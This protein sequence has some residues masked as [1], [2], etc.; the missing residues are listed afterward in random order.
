[1]GTMIAGPLAATMMADFGADV[2]KIEHPKNGDPIR[3]WTPIRNGV[4][5]WWKMT[6][7]N[8][9]LITLDLARQEGRELALELVRNADLVIENFRPGT[10]ERWGLGYDAMSNANPRVILVRVSG[11]GQTGPY[12]NRPGY[13]TVAEAMSGIPSFTGFPD[14]PPTLSAFPLADS[15]AALFG[16]FGGMFAWYECQKSGHGQVVDVSLFEPLFRL[17][18]SQVV[19]FDQLGIVKQRRGN[20]LDEDSPRN[21]YETS[22]GEF[23]AISASSE[24]TFARLAAAIGREDLTADPRFKDNPSRIAN[25]DALDDVIAAWFRAR[26]A[27]EAL[28]TLELGDVVAGPIYDIRRIFADAQYTARGA[29]TRVDDPDVGPLRMQSAIPLFSRT[30]GRVRHAGL[31]VGNDNA[32]VYREDL[33]LTEERYDALRKAGVI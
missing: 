17:V 16:A 19:G 1:M 13:G 23:I 25:A 14:G 28:G 3:T 20:R 32:S 27:D 31:S 15:V 33:G 11:Y 21:A 12:R 2:V 24:R 7:R 10:L 8:K 5:L 22:D 4:S 18:E 6:S 29:V 30:P 9:R 26:S